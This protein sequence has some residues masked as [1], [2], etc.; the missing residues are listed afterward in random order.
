MTAANRATRIGKLHSL[1]KKAYKPTIVSDNRPLIEHLLYACLLENSPYELADEA[2]ARLEQEYFDWNEV[3]VTTIT[4]LSEV[5]GR[6]PDPA[7]AALRL[8]KNLHSL[9]ESVYSF[10]LEELKKQNLGKALQRFERLPAM[11]PFVLAYITQHGLGGH[12]IPLD[13]AALRYFWLADIINENELKTGRVTGL[14]RA[15]PKNKG[16]EFASLLHQAAVALNI[17]PNDS[18]ARGIVV[19][20]NPE[21][22]QKVA[23]HVA[24]VKKRREEKA[25][26]K[27]DAEELLAQ[28][29]PPPS[30]NAKGSKGAD[31]A[32]AKSAAKPAAEVKPTP[33]SKK[34]TVTDK[35][36]VEKAA[37]PKPT[38]TK[39]D[40]A[41]AD[42]S[43]AV[44]AKTATAKPSAAK[45]TVKPPIKPGALKAVVK[46]AASG[47]KAAPPEAASKTKGGK[48]QP[49]PPDAGDKKNAEATDDAA[50]KSE[51]KVSAS[52]SSKPAE[53]PAI[54]KATSQDDSAASKAAAAV[55]KSSKRKP[56]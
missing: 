40:A 47:E 19:A 45:P 49:A 43:K 42:T 38:A 18:V 5:L 21:L 35:A 24:A 51:S 6:L 16:S 14:E 50:S 9:F 34:K 10:D 25:Q 46:K 12:A 32:N 8:K 11:T 48:S 26:A 1:L 44:D 20:L 56:R 4:E 33:E 7:S 15:I 37:A 31:K 17:D 3:R 22:D 30:K 2:L 41:N 52:S 36:V 27:A 13:S 53:K 28:A 54:K 39:P 23:D 29:T 55:K